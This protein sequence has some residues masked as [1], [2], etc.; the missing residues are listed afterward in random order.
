MCLSGSIGRKERKIESQPIMYEGEK[1]EMLSL[2]LQE[3]R[4]E[5]GNKI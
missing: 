1:E 4:G 5:R 3:E 2:G